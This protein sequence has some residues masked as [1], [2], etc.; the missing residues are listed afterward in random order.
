MSASNNE[1]TMRKRTIAPATLTLAAVFAVLQAFASP[2]ATS[3]D[4]QRFWGQWR[5]PEAT[6]VSKSAEPPLEWSETKNIRWKIEIPGRGSASPVIW[7]DRIFVLSAIP[8]GVEV[9]ASHAPRGGAKPLIP[10]RFIVLAIDRRDGRTIWQRTA[11]EEAPHEGSHQDNG[12]W[13]SSSAVTD[14]Q[15]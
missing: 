5:G 13:A 1:V 2:Q 4:A 6:G 10:H 7:G 9:G 8:I 12:T 11:R 15:H 14:G 3:T